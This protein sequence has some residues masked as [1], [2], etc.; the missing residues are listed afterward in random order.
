MRSFSIRWSRLG[1]HYRGSVTGHVDRPDLG[2]ALLAKADPAIPHAGLREMNGSAPVPA[3]CDRR[4]EEPLGQLGLGMTRLD[5]NSWMGTRVTFLD[6]TNQGL[7][8]PLFPARHFHEGKRYRPYSGTGTGEPQQRLRV[9]ASFHQLRSPFWEG[10]GECFGGSVGVWDRPD[11]TRLPAVSRSCQGFTRT[12]NHAGLK[13]ACC[14]DISHHAEGARRGLWHV[15][16]LRR[17]LR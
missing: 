15:A 14:A 16:P 6:G 5:R 9:D 10:H 7:A 12:G 17:W 3:G 1:A 4:S 8:P 13:I 11:T 2:R